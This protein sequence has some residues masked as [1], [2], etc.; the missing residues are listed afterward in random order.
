MNAVEPRLL[1]C[2]E[3]DVRF[4]LTWR[5][6]HTWPVMY[7]GEFSIT[8]TSSVAHHAFITV[9]FTIRTTHRWV[10]ASAWLDL[11]SFVGRF[12][13]PI[14]DHNYI[15]VHPY[16]NETKSGECTTLLWKHNWCEAH[17]QAAD[18]NRHAF[19][20]VFPSDPQTGLSISGHFLSHR[21]LL[22]AACAEG[23]KVDAEAQR[24]HPDYH[25]HKFV[26]FSSMPPVLFST[27]LCSR[28]WWAYTWCFFFSL[29]VMASL[30]SLLLE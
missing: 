19:E 1:Y 15:L 5:S 2:C 20:Y 30:S 23:D 11:T 18:F 14:D 12:T 27:Y 10:L 16:M 29:W 28:G 4:I 26:F 7:F 22:G 8:L 24:R 21:L 3:S 17:L 6:L 9:G 25:M 13:V